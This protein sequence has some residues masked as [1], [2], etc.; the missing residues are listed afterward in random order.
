MDSDIRLKIEKKIRDVYQLP[1]L[2]ATY[3]RLRKV[4]TNPKT[5]AQDVSRIIE[6]DQALA[7]KVLKIVNSAFYS[8]P[9]KV[10]TI[11]HA[12]VILGFNEIRNIAFSASVVNL[13][14]DKSQGNLFEY[15]AFW[16]H[17][18]AVGVCSRVIAK[19]VG[20]SLIRNPEEAFMAGL[21]HDI[22]KITQDQFMHDDY[23]PV[24]E[25]CRDQKMSLRDAEEKLLEFDHQHVGSYLAENWNLPNILTAP[26]S[27]HNMPGAQKH[28]SNV[29]PMICTVHVADALVRA[30]D[31][32]SGGDPYVPAINSD[33]WNCLGLKKSHVE[34]IMNDTAIATDELSG[35]GLP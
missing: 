33:C 31:I 30:L 7:T 29:Y 24:L 10:S 28:D 13:F 25:L 18:L 34:V 14:G 19:V 16:K 5:S 3:A 23:V 32:G 15:E 21:I 26:I 9:Q 35:I 8:F 27:F 17:A 11:A 4:M 12:A 1:T 2:P 6:A 22:G 20:T